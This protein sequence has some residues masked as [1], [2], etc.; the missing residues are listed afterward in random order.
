MRE[1]GKGPKIG[2]KGPKIAPK[3]GKSPWKII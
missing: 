2:P 3:K 1:N